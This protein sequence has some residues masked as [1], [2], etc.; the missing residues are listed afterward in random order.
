MP[1]PV[2]REWGLGPGVAI[3]PTSAANELGETVEKCPFCAEPV[4]EDIVIYGGTCPNCFAEI[5]GEEAPTNP[6]DEVIAQQVEA[7]RKQAGLRSLV[8]ALLIAALVLGLGAVA[9]VVVMIPDPEIVVMD[10][11][12][13]DDWAEPTIVA[14]KAV[15]EDVEPE[16][17]GAAEVKQPRPTARP[18]PASGEVVAAAPKAVAKPPS[19]PG[20]GGTTARSSG[21]A[22]PGP[23]GPS[24]GPSL[25]RR[26][27]DDGLGLTGVGEVTQ[28]R[29]GDI[30]DD[31]DAIR[32]SVGENMSKQIP[33][34]TAC[35]DQRLKTVPDLRGRWRI[36]FTVTKDGRVKNAA[37]SG[38]QAQDGEFEA[39]LSREVAKWKFERMVREQP[40]QRTL[41][42]QPS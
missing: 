9:I 37:A 35:Y 7:D 24:A 6:G 1:G 13:F 25:G 41:R 5:P 29:R 10:F 28:S 31:P 2:G 22:A 21:G 18:A 40:V 3:V 36:K 20:L 4:S 38:L 14:N 15:E 27:G 42:F 26:S 17:G 12:E 39:C 11:D 32:K 23:A 30:L 33:R 19:V 16:A 8:P 34:L